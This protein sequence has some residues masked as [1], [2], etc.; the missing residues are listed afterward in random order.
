MPSHGGWLGTLD[1]YLSL[2]C[3]ACTSLKRLALPNPH[4]GDVSGGHLSPRI[5]FWE[6]MILK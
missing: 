4:P 3:I 5:P 6:S 1:S 2:P